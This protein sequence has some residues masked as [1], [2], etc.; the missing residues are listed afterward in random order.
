MGT[1]S[2]SFCEFVAFVIK[3]YIIGAADFDLLR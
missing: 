2:G 3:W 1:I